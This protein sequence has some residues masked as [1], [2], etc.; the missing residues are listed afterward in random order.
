MLKCDVK[1]LLR[2]MGK[3]SLEE[4]AS[5]VELSIELVKELVAPKI[6]Q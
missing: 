2:K 5:S 4:I 3:L 6:V 1:L